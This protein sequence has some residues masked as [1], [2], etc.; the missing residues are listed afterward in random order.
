MSCIPDKDVT[1]KMW[2]DYQRGHSLASVARRYKV[3]PQTVYMRFKRAGLKRRTIKEAFALL[4]P[5][6]N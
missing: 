1:E 2:A 5:Q 6:D 4:E 3:T